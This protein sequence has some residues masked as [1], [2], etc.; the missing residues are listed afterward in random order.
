MSKSC[1]VL[2]NGIPVKCRQGETLLDAALGGRILLP[3]DCCSGQCETCRVRVL[4]GNIDDQGTRE[5]DTVLGC[6]ATIEG[7]SEISYDP[8]PIVRN[9]NALLEEV[10]DIGHDFLQ[11]R[12]RPT[13]RVTWLPG[14]YVRLTFRGYPARD[15]SPTFPLV[16]DRQ[17][18]LLT[19]HVRRYPDGI[20]SDA[21]GRR[22]GPGHK[23]SVRGPYGSAFLRHQPEP[24][25]LTSTGSG[26]APTWAMAVSCVL[27]QPNRSIQI[28]AGASTSSHLYMTPCINWLEMRGV[29]VLL[30]A[31]DGDGV[32]TLRDRPAELLSFLSA[33]HV[34]YAA[35][36]PSMV[37]SVGVRAALVGAKFHSDAFY[38]APAPSP[39]RKLVLR[40]IGWRP[41]SGTGREL[42]G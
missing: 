22:I 27:G 37:H 4:A 14:Q 24:L 18:D 36:A 41:G 21:L 29:P 33:S 38:P 10:S 19:F 17:E 12:L 5:G 8:V 7:D 28:V 3:H 34:V 23:V 16:L 11:V 35:G 9:T 31:G 20:V 2:I 13:R 30:T 15:Y 26:F 25:V 6:L 40:G 42:R 39:L 1:V 32:S